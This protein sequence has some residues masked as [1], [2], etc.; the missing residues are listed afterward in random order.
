MSVLILTIPKAEGRLGSPDSEG[1]ER[2]EDDGENQK[3]L[4]HLRSPSPF[5]RWLTCAITL[6][7]QFVQESVLKLTMPL[8]FSQFL[9]DWRVVLLHDRN[10]EWLCRSTALQ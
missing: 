6:A 1:K 5:K 2:N 9:V 7:H 8:V 3:L 4:S 10:F